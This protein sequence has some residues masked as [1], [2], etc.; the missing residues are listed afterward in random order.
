LKALKIGLLQ[1]AAGVLS[2]EKISPP[3]KGRENGIK[4]IHKPRAISTIP[5]ISKKL[6]FFTAR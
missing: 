5:E 4:A 3:G 6:F 1:E 2:K